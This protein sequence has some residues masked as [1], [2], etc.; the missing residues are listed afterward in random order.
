MRSVL[1]RVTDAR[2]SVDGHSVGAI[3]QGL[4]VY[5][6]VE[7]DDTEEDLAYLVEK[8]PRMR[9]FADGEGKMNRS[10]VDVGGSILAISQFTLCADVHK[11]NRPSFDPAASPTM[12]RLMYDR[13]VRM[14]REKGLTVATGEFGASMCVSYTNEGPVTILLDSPA[15][16]K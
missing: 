14:L 1:Q 11:G 9:L 4:L 2:V 8:I 16:M 6:G 13:F 12:A 7:R 3:G 10:V 15:K 5:L